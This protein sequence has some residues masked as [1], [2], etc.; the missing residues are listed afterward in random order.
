VLWRAAEGIWNNLV[1]AQYYYKSYDH[2]WCLRINGIQVRCL[3]VL[4]TILSLL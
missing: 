2:M 3:W 4:L 1:S